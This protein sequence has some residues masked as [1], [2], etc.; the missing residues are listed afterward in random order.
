MRPAR[1]G[2]F[3]SRR[4]RLS[5]QPWLWCWFST[6][7]AAWTGPA[8]T[9]AKLFAD[10]KATIPNGATSI[11][12]G[13]ELA[14]TTIDTVTGYDNKAIIVFTDGLENTY[15]YIKDV[16]D[17][18]TDRTFAIGL[19]TAQQVSTSSLTAL[20]KGTGGYLLISGALSTAIDDYFRLSKYFLQILA[21]VTNNNG[22][23]SEKC[24]VGYPGE[25]R[26]ASAERLFFAGSSSLRKEGGADAPGDLYQEG[27]WSESPPGSGGSGGGGSAGRGDRMDGRAG[28]ELWAVSA[29]D[30]AGSFASAG[31]RVA[32]SSDPGPGDGSTGPASADSL[33]RLWSERGE[34]AVGGSVAANHPVSFTGAGR[35]VA[36]ALVERDSHPLRGGL[37]DGCLGGQACGGVGLEA[38]ALGTAS[39]HRHRR[40]LTQQGAAIP[41]AGL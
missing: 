19:G 2:P 26:S 37:E 4:I 23:L 5:V 25:L 1:Y 30:Q 7:Q 34:L 13:L 14:R 40:G 12:N 29:A 9:R 36:Q 15:K 41:H 11:G 18:I 8:V 27:S 10:V 39:S 22:F 17:L 21:A 31:A 38:P 20:T 16:K 6:N 3:P 33:S 28:F 35:A 24:A 32:G